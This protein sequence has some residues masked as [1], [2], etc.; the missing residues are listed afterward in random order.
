MWSPLNY[1]AKTFATRSVFSWLCE[2]LPVWLLAL[3]SLIAITCEC[4]SHRLRMPA[5]AF[6][7]LH[8]HTQH[9]AFIRRSTLPCLP[10]ISHPSFAVR[11]AW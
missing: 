1:L 8:T 4:P 6:C 11:S 7:R 10:S 2:V 3:Q 5:T 9:L